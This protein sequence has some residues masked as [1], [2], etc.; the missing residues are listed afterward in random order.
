[1]RTLDPTF[2][3]SVANHETV[4]PF[5]KGE[6]FLDLA[7]IS[8]PNNIALQYEGGGWV[9][10]KVSD[11]VYEVHSMFLPEVRG[12]QV[13]EF[14]QKALA[15]VFSETDCRRI[16]TQLPDGNVPARALARKA[17]FSFWFRKAGTDYLKLDLED[18]VQKSDECLKAGEDF[19][20]HLEAAKVANGSSLEAHADD[21]AHDHAVGAALLMCRSGNPAKGVWYYNAWA[22]FAG[23]VPIKLVSM[24]PMV[25]DVVDAVLEGPDM[26]VLLCR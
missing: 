4:R 5:L 10:N 25:I 15:Y 3:I 8:D 1:M 19:H 9:L 6:G 12:A 14:L 18:W 22:V 13:A 17:G 20:N 21:A 11:G 16:L 7:L 26:K 23:Y 2:L 24:N